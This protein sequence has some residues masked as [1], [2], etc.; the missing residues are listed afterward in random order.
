MSSEIRSARPADLAPVAATLRSAG[1]G[2]NVGRLLEFPHRS[3]G[4]D[5]L[6]ALERSEGIGGA[7]VAGFG[8]TG[9]IGALG[10]IGAVRRRGVGTALTEA[11]V[12]WLREHGARTVLLYATEAGRP[13]YD[14]VGF[15]SDGQAQ[16]WR[17]VA[18][19]PTAG[20]PPGVRPLGPQD[21]GA[22]RALD[23]AA[24]GEDRSSVFDALGPFDNG[25]GIAV[26]RDGRLAGSALRS[27]WGL[28]PSVVAEDADA[29]L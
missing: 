14:R 26:E 10:V 15:V 4:G 28:G 8:A 5:V 25:A 1:L 6:V 19:P 20:P 16:A 11:A 21:G 22:V 7:A 9:W 13:V 23:A 17:D 27:P 18:P 2:A 29:G 24:T 12:T 3:P